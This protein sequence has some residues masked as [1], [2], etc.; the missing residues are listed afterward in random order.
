MKNSYHGIN[1]YRLSNALHN[2]NVCLLFIHTIDYNIPLY[3]WVLD[4]DHQINNRSTVVI[5]TLQCTMSYIHL[6]GVQVVDMSHWYLPQTIHHC[7]QSPISAQYTLQLVPHTLNCLLQA[8]HLHLRLHM[9]LHN[10]MIS[11]ASTV[12]Q[13]TKINVVNDTSCITLSHQ[14]LFACK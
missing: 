13:N 14:H 6:M 5:G 11:H 7:T 3:K 9:H 8:S 2:I 4:R 12:P 10:I 1:D